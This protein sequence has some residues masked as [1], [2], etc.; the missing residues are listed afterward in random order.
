MKRLYPILGV[1][2][3]FNSYA[4]APFN[5]IDPD[6]LIFDAELPDECIPISC[7]GKDQK[8]VL[9][10]DFSSTC[11]DYLYWNDESPYRLGVFCKT[12]NDQSQ[13]DYHPSGVYWQDNPVS[14]HCAPHP[15]MNFNSSTGVLSLITK[16]DPETFTN[17]ATDCPGTFTM[18]YAAA[19][20]ESTHSYLYGK[21]EIRAKI[22]A[23]DGYWPAFWLFDVGDNGSCANEIDV[24]ELRGSTGNVIPTNYHTL[25]NC[26]N[27]QPVS[28]DQKD[29]VPVGYDQ[30][31]WNV[32]A[33]EW[34]FFKIQWILDG[35][36]IR[37]V[38]HYFAEP[39]N[40]LG[41]GLPIG[42]CEELQAA[43]ASSLFGLVENSNFPTNPMKLLLTAGVADVGTS[44]SFGTPDQQDYPVSFDVDYVKITQCCDDQQNS[45]PTC[46]TL[47]Q[48]FP[49][50]APLRVKQIKY[51]DNPSSCQS[52]TVPNGSDLS[53][54]AVYKINFTPNTFAAPGSYVHAQ[55]KSPVACSS[56][57]PDWGPGVNHLLPQTPEKAQNKPKEKVL[58][59]PKAISNSLR[60][61]PNPV[62]SFVTVELN[63][64]DESIRSLNIYDLQGKLIDIR[65]STNENSN[66]LQFDMSQYPIGTYLIKVN[67]DR[68]SYLQKI[69]RQ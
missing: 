22:D 49:E 40:A 16:Y 43:A 21:F 24:F 60:I 65:S 4:Q 12:F 50:S 69:V 34:D 20:L 25:P 35:T 26:D 54:K 39:A 32:Y 53:V 29:L 9:F 3:A 10:D 59:W 62:T 6:N 33:V 8:V 51:P 18:D 1:L 56:T 31:D 63:S 7:T 27:T 13:Q 45:G 67:T 28:S 36:V 47:N 42:N 68:N 57:K 44:H 55:I 64:N 66:H 23:V 37:T 52:F 19:H 48:N 17:V 41:T 5:G 46:G 58:E 61:T 30:T 2:F 15:L 14:R 38:H 11:L